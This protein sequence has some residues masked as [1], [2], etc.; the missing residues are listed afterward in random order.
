MKFR[1]FKGNDRRRSRSDHPIDTRA[2]TFNFYYY[3][4]RGV[5]QAHYFVSYMNT[6]RSLLRYGR[7]SRGI[8]LES[9]F[10][11]ELIILRVFEFSNFSGAL[12]PCQGFATH[13]FHRPR[14]ENSLL[15]GNLTHRYRKMMGKE[16]PAF[17]VFITLCL[18]SSYPMNIE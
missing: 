12:H 13:R 9:N 10:L 8:L 15:N 4:L 1:T 17:G 14:L 2:N 3:D 7:F 18:D 11:R 16:F 6:R 5:C